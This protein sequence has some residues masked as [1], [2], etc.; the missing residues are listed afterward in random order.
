MKI[1]II[2]PVYRIP[3]DLL[4]ACVD[5]LRQQTLDGMEFLFVVDGADDPA[6]ALLE[7]ETRR[8]D[9]V[10]MQVNE[11]R[12]GVSASRNRGLDLATGAWIGFVDAD[13]RVEPQMYEKLWRLAQN[14]DCDLMGCGFAR[15]AADGSIR[16]DRPFEG[17][18]ELETDW[19]AARVYAAAKTSCCSKLFRK[20]AIR[21]MYFQPHLSHMEDAVF[22]TVALNRSRRVGFL[23]EPLYRVC[24]RAD[25]AHRTPMTLAGFKQVYRALDCLAELGASR[26]EGARWMSRLW[27]W[28]LLQWSLAAR[29]YHDELPVESHEQALGIVQRFYTES[30]AEFHRVYPVWLRFMLQRR[31]R[32][33][34]QFFGEPGWFYTLLWNRIRMGLAPFESRSRL[35][36]AGRLR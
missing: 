16:L 30:L 23:S 11:T 20:A 26:S 24:H 7:G 15:E 35:A 2:V 14:Q 13:D 25:S 28:R 12:Q 29:R 4:R 21:G 27:A 34:K 3:E 9:R 32:G 6:R 10:R 5:S 18:A 17:V 36:A 31:M 33:S 19:E 22:L 8:D 1:S